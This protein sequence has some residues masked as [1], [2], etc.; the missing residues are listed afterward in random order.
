MSE[1]GCP[2][3]VVRWAGVGL[4]PVRES[5]EA[6]FGVV[7]GGEEMMITTRF[8]RHSQRERELRDTSRRASWAQ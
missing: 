5:G 8:K 3:C 1:H 4:R 6:R 2:C 7:V